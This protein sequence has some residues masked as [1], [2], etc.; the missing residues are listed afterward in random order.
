MAEDAPI[1]STRQL[2]YDYARAVDD[3]DFT[4]L[5]RILHP[6]VRMA[7]PGFEA[8]SR[9][10]FFETLKIL[11]RYRRT[12]HFVG[13]HTGSWSAGEFRG[14]TYCV[15]SH[16]YEHEG[17]VRKLDMGIRYADHIVREGGALRFRERVLDVVWTQDLPA[18]LGIPG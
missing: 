3:R 9:A 8:L 16:L 4:L 5:G 14:E 11:E 13:N 10:T 6:E 18:A 17:A 7:G 1:E 12:F 15:A 2:A